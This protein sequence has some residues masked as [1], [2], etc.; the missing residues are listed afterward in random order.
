ME[1]KQTLRVGWRYIAKDSFRGGP[2]SEFEKGEIVEFLDSVFSPYDN[3]VVYNFSDKF[4]QIKEWLPSDGAGPTEW[5]EYFD[6]FC[7]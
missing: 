2:E 1:Y 4:G 3:T 5:N 7:A 6:L